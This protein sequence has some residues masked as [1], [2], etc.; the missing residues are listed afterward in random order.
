MNQLGIL[1]QTLAEM[2]PTYEK[3][4]RLSRALREYM[5]ALRPQGGGDGPNSATTTATSAGPG[6]VQPFPQ[7]MTAEMTFNTQRELPLDSTNPSAAD[8]TMSLSHNPATPSF[9]T[10]NFPHD[11]T[12]APYDDPSSHPHFP[13]FDGSEDWMEIGSSNGFATGGARAS[14]AVDEPAIGNSNGARS[15]SHE[16]GDDGGGEAGESR[17]TEDAEAEEPAEDWRQTI[18]AIHTVTDQ[19][20]DQTIKELFGH[21]FHFQVV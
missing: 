13:E 10:L 19:D 7:G 16:G 4:D 11:S 12:S 2:S 18:R 3:A 6:Y 9:T 21:V 20:H 8:I 15:G 14:S 17:E 1:D 5:A